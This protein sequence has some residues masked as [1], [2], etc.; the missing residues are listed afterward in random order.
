MVEIVHALTNNLIGIWTSSSLAQALVFYEAFMAWT[1]L[2]FMPVYLPIGFMWVFGIK[3]PKLVKSG[4]KWTALTHAVLA[5]L[6][7][8][9]LMVVGGVLY[10]AY[11]K[12]RRPPA[13]LTPRSHT[14][15]PPEEEHDDEEEG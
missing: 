10:L 2:M 13:P 5:L 8:A 15:P 12:S 14:A 1:I 11:T 3:L 4:L 9:P 6:P 7:G